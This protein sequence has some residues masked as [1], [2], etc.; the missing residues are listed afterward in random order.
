MTTMRHSS[1][2]ATEVAH[3]LGAGADHVEQ[4][5]LVLAMPLLVALPDPIPAAT[6][7][8]F[9]ALSPARR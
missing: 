1:P 5:T 8:R 2:R 7:T 4:A 3:G 9:S 6:A